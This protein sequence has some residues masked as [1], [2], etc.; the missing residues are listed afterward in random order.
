MKGIGIS[1]V[2]VVGAI[3]FYL[4]YKSIP[5]MQKYGV[6]QMLL[7]CRWEPVSE[8]PSYGISYMIGT[9]LFGSFGA[10]ALAMPIGLATAVY[11]S[12]LAPKGVAEM[13]ETVVELMAGIP[14]I[15]YGLVGLILIT[16]K[17]QKWE[18]AWLQNEETAH[19]F[20]GGANLLTAILVLAVM[21]LPMVIITS[22]AAIEA[23]PQRIRLEAMVLGA[24]RLQT[25]FSV[26]LE[27]ADK[28]IVTAGIL[29]FGRILGETMVVSFVAGGVVN[30]PTPFSS[31]RFLTTTLVSEMGYA[32]GTHR[33]ALFLIG[34]ILYVL[35]LVLI[36]GGH[37]LATKKTNK[38]ISGRNTD[39]SSFGN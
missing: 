25:I 21:I 11:I 2:A 10:L 30:R 9:S 38:K 39:T 16:P 33:E 24:S 22:K 28:G 6:G 18:Q 23:V 26:V 4:L 5:F 27:E 12:E 8:M 15:I 17:V 7:N 20:S 13:L 19:G 37:G 1:V 3:T 36:G 29:A 31:V 35:I 14:S 34:W 32:K